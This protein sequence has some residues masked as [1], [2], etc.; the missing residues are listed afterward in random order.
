MVRYIVFNVMPAVIASFF[1]I[2]VVYTVS[3]PERKKKA[4]FVGEN[5]AFKKIYSPP[6]LAIWAL[7]TLVLWLDVVFNL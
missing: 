5:I 2:Y 6:F 4:M 3:K 7:I 1:L